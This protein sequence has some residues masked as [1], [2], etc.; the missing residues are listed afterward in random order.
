M[1]E[2]KY[3]LVPDSGRTP[4]QRLNDALKIDNEFSQLLQ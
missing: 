3:L 4:L 1:V 2:A